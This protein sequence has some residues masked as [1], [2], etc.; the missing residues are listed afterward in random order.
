MKN[1][2]PEETL[3]PE[4]W[5]GFKRLAHQALEDSLDYLATVRERPAWQPYPEEVRRKLVTPPPREGQGAEGAYR[6]Y[7]ELVA[8]W[9]RGNIHPRF[10]A[11]VIG[12][13]TPMSVV[14]EML[15]ATMNVNAT[16]FDQSS[17]HVELQILSWFKELMGFPAEGSGIL[18]SG[19]SVANL[20]ALNVARSAKAPFAVRKQGVSGKPRLMFYASSEAHNSVQRA[21]ELMGLGAESLAYVPVNEDYKVDMSA[22]K[23][24][25]AADRRAG[26]LPLCVVANAGT[27]NTGAV[28][29]I[30]VIADF[31]RDE[32]L[33]LHVDGAFGALAILDPARRGLLKGMERA[34]SLAFDLHKW[35]YLPMDVG[36]VLVRSEQ[37]H[38][39][40]FAVP[41][42]YLAQQ[43]GGMSGGPRS[44]SDYGPQLSRSFRALKVWMNIKAYGLDKFG[45][46][47]AQNVRQA[48]YLAERVR[49]EP[50]LELMAPVPLNV[51]NFR[52]R[53]P[54]LVP[55][56]ED[57]LNSR[58]LVEMQ[59]RGIAAPSST[60]L[61]GRFCIRVAITNHRSRR[62]DFDALVEGTLALGRGFAR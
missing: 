35:M 15:M 24:R 38:R 53:V 18:V 40:A 19:G 60:V 55:E 20:V 48:E 52:Y 21:L 43:Q 7:Q 4:D 46:L 30:D 50:D 56:A 36:C 22:L 3:D 16:G 28:D 34:D 9:P 17:T 1:L 14:A 59:R 32:Q 29:D 8:P 33:W 58:I 57:A 39:D 54:G 61:K 5:E 62:E 12:T 27:V 13:G 23:A 49:S 44:T 2:P 31:C 42:S 11:W 41:A 6:D 45:R 47:I 51:V 25:I 37:A 10:W 26:H